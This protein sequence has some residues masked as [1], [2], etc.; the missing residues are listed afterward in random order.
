MHNKFSL[1]QITCFKYTQY[2]KQNRSCI[3]HW[4]NQNQHKNK[5]VKLN[6]ITSSNVYS[7]PHMPCHFGIIKP[8][9]VALTILFTDK[10]SSTSS[11][12]LYLPHYNG[13]C[14]SV[15]MNL[16]INRKSKTRQKRT[17]TKKK[18]YSNKTQNLQ[19]LMRYKLK[20]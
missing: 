12:D 16:K 20:T 9:F 3:S 2:I 8:T 1:N 17:K 11:S 14:S 7:F 18:N 13:T 4:N 6:W 15:R 10:F 5:E 19:K